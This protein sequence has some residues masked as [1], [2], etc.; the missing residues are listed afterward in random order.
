MRQHTVD[1]VCG[2][3]GVF[4]RT[5]LEARLLQRAV[6]KTVL[7]I[8]DGRFGVVASLFFYARRGTVAGMRQFVEVVHAL[9]AR[10][11]LAQIVKY[12]TVVLQQFQGE[13]SGRVV[14][15]DMLVGLQVFLDM[16][17]TILYLMSVIDMQVAR[18]FV[19]ALI[20]LDDGAEQVLHA[21]TAFERGGNHRDAEQIAERVEVHLVAAALKLVV[22]VQCAHHT[23]IHIHQLGCQ[24]EITFDVRGVDNVDY[25]VGHL[26]R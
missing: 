17:D 5:R 6:D 22:H 14:L 3:V 4:L 25:Y 23:D 16:G 2:A 7:C 15:G 21:F 20:H 12:L 19:G 9:F 1:H 8:H 18:P 26:F 10:H 13:V 11:V 24:V